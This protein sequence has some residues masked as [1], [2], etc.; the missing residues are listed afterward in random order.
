M[1]DRQKRR[2]I[3]HRVAVG[4]IG[5]KRPDGRRSAPSKLDHFE[6][7]SCELEDDGFARDEEA[8]ARLSEYGNPDPD[9]PTELPIRVDSDNIDDWLLQEYQCHI[10]ARDGQMR[11]WCHGDGVT[12]HRLQRDGTSK[13][14]PC[15]SK[16]ESIGG[17][18][19]RNLR[20]LV[21]LLRAPSTD[22]PTKAHRCPF[23]QNRDPKDGPR[24]L[25]TTEMVFRLE[26][27]NNIGSRARF[28]SHAHGTADEL[29]NSLEDIQDMMPG[30]VLQHVPLS[31]V[32]RKRKTSIPG[33]K[34]TWQP[35]VSARLRVDLDRA[36]ELV[37]HQLQA[38]GALAERVTHARLLERARTELATEDEVAAEWSEVAERPSGGGFDDDD[39]DKADGTTNDGGGAVAREAKGAEVDGE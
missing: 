17:A 25:P 32:V 9:N 33:G 7:T 3:S 37:N 13:D 5:R 20:D 29:R 39:E 14:V 10:K 31:L 21:P 28:R 8:H 26:V 18:P 24:C 38:R 19:E 16:P 6:I 2:V 4:R 15:M 12:A 22:V 11:I 35:A 1:R 23:A 27:V 34:S 36:I 30:G